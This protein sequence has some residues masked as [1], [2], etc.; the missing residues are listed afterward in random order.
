MKRSSTVFLQIVLVLIGI[1]ALALMLW[2]PRI[3]GRN[4]NSTNFEIY[5]KDPFLAYMYFASTSF[6]LALFNGFK[7]LGFA[8]KNHVF[9]MAAVKSMRTIKFCALA[10]AGFVAIAVLVILR[11]ESDDAAGG[12]VMG[13][14]IAFVSIVISAA[15]ALFERVLQS[16]VDIKSENDLTV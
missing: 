11:N 9:S 8:G 14:L 1:G 13:V 7:L 12:V 2:L 15:A 10:L 16:A 6:F 5:F 3:E 4:V